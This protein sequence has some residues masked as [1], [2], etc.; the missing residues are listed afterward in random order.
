MT[1]DTI[2]STGPLDELLE[3]DRTVCVVRGAELFLEVA[4]VEI[5]IERYTSWTGPADIATIAHA[6]DGT[7]Q[8]I[9]LVA[10]RSCGV[11]SIAVEQL[12]VGTTLRLPAPTVAVVLIEGALT[13]VTPT[14]GFPGTPERGR[15][16]R[17]DALIVDRS[18]RLFSTSTV[19]TAIDSVIAFV[20]FDNTATVP[21]K[22]DD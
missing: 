9:T 12:P 16:A 5:V 1:L 22:V 6:D 20:L 14:S 21:T 4:G 19:T 3:H 18:D 13:I 2:E 10:H 7:R 8:S 15:A 11:G 17:F